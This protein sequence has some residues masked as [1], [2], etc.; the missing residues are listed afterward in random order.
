MK[1]K[2]HSGSRREGELLSSNFKKGLERVAGEKSETER[3][4]RGG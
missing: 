1:E 2:A 3:K 4:K